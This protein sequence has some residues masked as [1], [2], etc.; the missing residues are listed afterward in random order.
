MKA[1]LQR[2]AVLV[3]GMLQGFDRLVFKGKLRQLYSP[4]GMHIL[5]SANHVLRNDFKSMPPR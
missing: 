2:F 5:L 3:A 4:E 1:F